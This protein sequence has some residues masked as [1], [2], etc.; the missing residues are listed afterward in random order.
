MKGYLNRPE[1]TEE[2]FLGGWCHTGDMAGVDNDGFITIVD[3]KT[4]LIISG[5]ENIYPKE[6]EDVLRAHPA[7]SEAAVF[8]IPD[9]EWVEAVCAAIVLKPG[10]N[11][12]DLEII[13]YCRKNLASYKKPRTITFLDAL[14]K[15]EWGKIQKTVLKAHYSGN[16]TKRG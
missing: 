10:K 4:D 9:E 13:E 2:A 16:A 12:S 8:G 1:D 6:V 7:V 5:G 11:A 14:P 15:N 3:R